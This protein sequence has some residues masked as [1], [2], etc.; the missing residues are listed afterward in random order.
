VSTA[1]QR[2][3]LL[4]IIV[5]VYVAL[6]SLPHNLPSVFREGFGKDRKNQ[7]VGNL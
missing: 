5:A 2:C 4:L 1:G 3:L 6:T 7:R